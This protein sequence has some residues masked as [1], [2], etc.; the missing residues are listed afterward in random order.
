L[1]DF[2]LAVQDVD[3]SATCATGIDTLMVNVG[4]RCNMSCS[5]CH[6][7]SSPAR[8]EMM[9]RDDIDTVIRIASEVRPSLVDITGGAPELHP[10]IRRLTDGLA[11]AGLAVQL[12]TNLTALLEP[13]AE[14]L[15]DLMA[16]NKVRVLASLPGTTAEDVVHQRGGAFEKMIEALRLL[17]EAG[18]GR[19]RELRLD[20]AVNP[21]GDRLVEASEIEGAFRSDLEREYGV[22][23]DELVLI[24]NLPVGRFA[25]ELK[26]DGRLGGYRQEL[27]D[28]FNPDTVG[29]L[30]CRSTL[31]ILWDGTFS[32]CD[33]NA[34]AGLRVAEGVPSHISEFDLDALSWR[35]IRFGEHCF[36]CTARAGSG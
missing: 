13:E 21:M 31:D 34:G 18:Y 30:A 22:T 27:R 15:I 36:A 23:F 19:G 1:N 28:G 9:S 10:E 35:P 29:Q 7:S 32:D 24:T 8:D 6:Q 2:A 16:A 17:A 26:R 5:H 33:F 14:G 12:R 4:L 11:A 3:P 20:I 25:D